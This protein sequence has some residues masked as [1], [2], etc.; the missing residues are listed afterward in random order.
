MSALTPD[1]RKRR[2]RLVFAIAVLVGA[3]ILIIAVEYAAVPDTPKTN[4]SNARDHQ[5]VAANVAPESPAGARAVA[6]APKPVIEEAGPTPVRAFAAG[7]AA[8]PAAAPGE[9]AEVAALLNRPDRTARD[10]VAAVAEIV[11]NYIQQFH[12]APVGNNAE[13]TAALAGDNPR[14]HAGLRADN[15]AI[16]AK[17]ELTDRWG[18]PYFFHALAGDLMEIRSAGPDHRMF[19]DDDVV[20]PQPETSV[21]QAMP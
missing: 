11:T 10:D 13:I 5:D 19:N 2:L 20:W 1:Q 3:I 16:S 4:S 9:Y 14:G 12:E 15:P 7:P 18:T 17:G 8:P 21:A 6:P